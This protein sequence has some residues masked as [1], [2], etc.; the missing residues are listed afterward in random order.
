MERGFAVE[1]CKVESGGVVF[2]IFWHTIC[3]ILL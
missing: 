1:V 3:I 2:V